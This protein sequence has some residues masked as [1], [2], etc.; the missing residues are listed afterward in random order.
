MSLRATTCGQFWVFYFLDLHPRFF[1]AFTVWWAPG[2]TRDGEESIQFV[3][4]PAVACPD[5]SNGILGPSGGA[6]ST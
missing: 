1:E 3:P 4:D 5:P 6:F 2:L